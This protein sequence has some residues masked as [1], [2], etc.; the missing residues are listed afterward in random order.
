MGQPPSIGANP[1]T[2]T[3]YGV[4][5]HVTGLTFGSA[6]SAEF[7]FDPNTGRETQ[8][9]AT[10]NGSVMH[11]DLTWNANGSLKTLAI[12]DPF[13]AGDAQTCNYSYDDLSRITAAN[14]GTA[15]FNQNFAYDPFGN[16]TKTVPTGSTG[17]A[18]QPGYNSST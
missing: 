18:W 12:T 8:Y 11:G 15:I 5:S 14:C 9:S 2:S 6:D 7:A 13:N 16:I 1:V 17:I 4:S 10:V 3:S